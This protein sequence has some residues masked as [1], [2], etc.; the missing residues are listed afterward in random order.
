MSSL[1]KT[2]GGVVIAIIVI[3]GGLWYRSSHKASDAMQGQD[4]TA[5]ATT[6]VPAQTGP[7]TTVPAPVS[8]ISTSDASDATLNQ[9]N[10]N[11][12]TQV[13]N[14]NADV[15]NVDSGIND[16]PVSQQ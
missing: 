5:M 4:T 1:G 8:T 11:I 9:D 3:G 13:K 7:S 16:V 15:A 10:T 14:L 12:D 2:I 6:T